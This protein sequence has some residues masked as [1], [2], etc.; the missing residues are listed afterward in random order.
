MSGHCSRTGC[1][2]AWHYPPVRVMSYHFFKNK[3]IVTKEVY[4]NVLASVVKPWMETV[5]SGRLYVFQQDGATAHTS[6]LVQNLLSDNI[7]MFWFKEF[8]PP[9]NPDLNLLDYY[10]WSCWKSH[11][12]VQ[13]SQCDVYKD[14]YW[15]SIRQYRPSFH[16]SFNLHLMRCRTKFKLMETH[17]TAVNSLLLQSINF[18]GLGAN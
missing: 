8:W 15:S 3:E 14:R 12:Q 9:N 7:D 17:L 5:A 11:Q 6:H 1:C 16:R 4:V 2:E 13:A 18:I 10:M